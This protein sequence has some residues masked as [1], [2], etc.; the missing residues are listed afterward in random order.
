[1]TLM[2]DVGTI[3]ARITNDKKNHRPLAQSVEDIERLYKDR[4]I[5]YTSQRVVVHIDPTES[6]STIASKIEQL[7]IR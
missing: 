3:I 1:M 6:I 5:H 2:A 4:Y 7:M